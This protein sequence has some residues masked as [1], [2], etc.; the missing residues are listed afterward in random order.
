MAVIR[1]PIRPP[2]LPLRQ[3]LGE[4]SRKVSPHIDTPIS[5]PFNIPNLFEQTSLYVLRK[6]TPPI[7]G[8]PMKEILDERRPSK[9]QPALYNVS[10]PWDPQ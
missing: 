9:I 10:V 7:P 1:D 6:N 4:V 8:R 3:V 2:P 5:T